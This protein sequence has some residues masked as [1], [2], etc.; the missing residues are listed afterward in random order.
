MPCFRHGREAAIYASK[1]FAVVGLRALYFAVAGLRALYFA[2]AGLN[3]P[4]AIC[5][6][7]SAPSES[8]SNH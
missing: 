3:R 2:V 6:L 1:I 8:R 7:I 4:T 5:G